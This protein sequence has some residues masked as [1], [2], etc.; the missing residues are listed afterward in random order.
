VIRRWSVLAVVL[1]LLGG[2]YSFASAPCVVRCGPGGECPPS[3]SCMEDRFCHAS[4]A[5]ALCPC[6]PLQC[7]E[8]EGACGDLPDTCG[9]VTSCGGCE[10]PLECG[11]GGTPNV[12]GDPASCEP[13]ACLPGACG[14]TIDSCGD[15]TVC[16]DCPPGTRCDQG[17][18]VDCT[19][20]CQP[21]ELA[22]GDDQCGGSCGSCPDA[23]WTCHAAGIC[24][25]RNNEQCHPLL[26]GCNCCPGLFCISGFC[27]PAAGC[28]MAP[29]FTPGVF[30]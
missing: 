17:K 21:G 11:G 3:F 15:P 1:G 23:R 19:P 20:Q 8:L 18:C 30:E 22:C 13:Q 27:T 26:E 9:G 5:E 6:K 12:C 16:P 2:C 28:A 7:H 14:P 4:T 24:C 10:A 25:I 29:D